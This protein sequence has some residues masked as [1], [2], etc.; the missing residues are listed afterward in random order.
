[1]KNIN[2]GL[3]RGL[4]RIAKDGQGAVLSSLHGNFQIRNRW[5]EVGPLSIQVKPAT[6][7][8]LSSEI[9]TRADFLLPHEE[10]K[11][12][13]PRAGS[14]VVVPTDQVRRNKR[15]IIPRGQRPHGLGGKA[16]VL[17]TK[18]G[19]VL[20]QRITRGKRKGLIVLYGMETNVRIKKVSTFYEPIEK[21]V[22]R[23]GRMHIDKSIADAL[24]TMR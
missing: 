19:P 18:K 13:K 6:P 17:Q 12:K 7:Q 10:G 2:F 5:P 3:A 4:T 15:S 20:A 1:M 22:S 21:V 9:R 23:R 24:N 14:H 8:D 11:D 16:F